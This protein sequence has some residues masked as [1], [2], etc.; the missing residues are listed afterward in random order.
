MMQSWGLQTQKGKQPTVQNVTHNSLYNFAGTQIKIC[1]HNIQQLR[2]SL[3]A[4]AV[5]THE[6]RKRLGHTDCIRQLQNIATFTPYIHT[7]HD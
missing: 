7:L 1:L 4:G 6:Y 2:I 3:Y 5:A